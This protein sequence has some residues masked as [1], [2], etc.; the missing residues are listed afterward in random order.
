MLDVTDPASGRSVAWDL[1]GFAANPDLLITGLAVGVPEPG[2]ATLL[3]LGLAGL[4]LLGGR[5]RRRMANR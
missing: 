1:S 4:W 2:S 5:R 3:G